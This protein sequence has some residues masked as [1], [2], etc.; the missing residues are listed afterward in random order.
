[1]K[2]KR[3]VSRKEQYEKLSAACE[4][5][6]K[7]KKE[8]IHTLAGIGRKHKLLRYPILV[9]LVVFIFIYNVILYGCIQLK[10]REKFARGV[11]FV[12]TLVLVLTS[13]NAVTFATTKRT[14]GGAQS[15][16]VITAFSGLDESVAKQSL[17][18]GAKE[19]GITFPD[20]LTVTLETES[21]EEQTESTEAKEKTTS[22]EGTEAE[23][24]TTSEESTESEGNT[25]EESTPESEEA[26]PADEKSNSADTPSSGN[27][28]SAIFNFLL[29]EPMIVYAAGLAETK[30]SIDV[31]WTLDT[32]ASTS[33][34]F[35]SSEAGNRYVY[36]PVIPDEYTVAEGVSL[37]QIIVTVID[38]EQTTV[39]QIIGWQFGE[40]NVFPEGALF[41]DAGSYS[42]VLA[43]GDSEVQ[44]PFEEIASC[45]PEN[46]LVKYAEEA[47]DDEVLPI[48]GWSCPEYTTDEEGNLPYSGSFFFTALLAEN[49]EEGEY[50]F[51]EEVEP[52]GVW[53]IFDAPM[54]TSV[55]AAPGTITSDQEWEEQ[56]LAAG[57]YII[58]EGVTVT[59]SG[60][61]TV[62]GTVTIK[63]GG[64]LVRS[65]SYAGTSGSGYNSALLY[66]TGGSLTL[67][68][69][70]IDGNF[71]EAYGPAVYISSGTVTLNSGAVIQNNYNMN[72][73]SGAGTYAA[74]GIY[75]AGTLNINGGTIQNCRTN[76]EIASSAYSYAGGGIYLKGTCNMTSGSITGNSASN[77]G[78]IYLASGATLDLIGGII[79][80]NS[81]TGNGN[82]IYY[83]TV[84]NT[85]GIL[86]IG[87]D[88][89]ISDTIYLD[90]TKGTLYPLITSEL[91]Y[92][93]TLNCNISEEGKVLARGS[94]YTLTDAD[95]SKIT[96]ENSGLYSV[97]DTDNNQII[98]REMEA[99]W[100]ETSGGEW[101]Y[102]EFTTAL[103]NVYSGGTIKLL[104]D[105]V[106]TEKV[107]IAKTVTITSNDTS[108]PCTI[109]RMPT[110]TYG[111]IT[112]T[113]SGNLTLT[114]IIYDGNRDYVSGGGEAQ[115][116]I[117]VGDT[118]NQGTALILGNGCVIRNGYKSGGSGV[119]A[120]YGTMTMES[121]AV[122]ENCQVTGT[123]GAVWVS[124]D[125]TFIMNGGTI[126]NCA[127][128]DGGSAVS[129]DGT[130]LLNGGSITGNTD[131]SDKTCDV[132]L[133]SSGS[134]SL[135]LNGV[136]ISGNTYSVYNEGKN[137]MITGDST[138]LGSIYT[139]NAVTASG[140][141]V[142]GL[143]KTYTITM[144]SVTN[145]TIVVKDSTDS[146]H[147]QLDSSE[148]VLAANGT[149]LWAAKKYTVTYD[150]SM[151]GGICA[152]KTSDMFG[153]GNQ[154]DLTPTAT[155]DGWEFVG[156]NTDKDAKTGLD[157]LTMET[158][159]MTLYAVYKKTLTLTCYSGSAGDKQTETVTIYNNDTKGSL[160]VPV[161]KAW[162]VSDE[163]YRFHHYVLGPD[164]FEGT[165]YGG[166]STI[167]LSEDISLYA[168][169]RKTITIS[170]EANEGSGSVADKEIYRSA[171]VS[172]I[173]TYKEASATLPEGTGFT[174]A[175]YTF[176]GWIEGSSI[177]TVIAAGTLVTP[178]ADTTYYASWTPNTYLVELH[179]NG[180]SG[181]TSLTS[182]TCGTGAVLP[183]DWTKSGYIFAGWYDNADCTG[184]EVAEILATDTGN[185]EYWAKWVDDI[186]PEIGTLSYSYQPKNLWQWLIGKESLIIT[187]PV[188][189]EGSGVDEI[190]YIVTEEG[191]TASTD[192]SEIVDGVAKIT[193]SADFKGTIVLFCTDK[194]GNT[195]SSVAVGSDMNGT[196]IIIEDNAPDIT[197][198][199]DGGDVSP[200]EY[201]LAPEI[202]VTV[203]DD[204]DN[205]ISAGIASVTYQIGNGVETEVQ[206]DF[207]TSMKNQVSFTIA[208]AQIPTGRTEI[209]VKA[210]DNAGNLSEKKFTVTV[211]VHSGNLVDAEAATCTE[212][213]HR[214]YYICSC[215]K[216]FSDSSCTKEVT[217][218]E[219]AILATGH[220]SVTDAA[221]AATCTKT[222]LTKGSHCS[223][224]GT[225]IVEQKTIKALG[226]DYSGNYR[227]DATGHWKVCRRC[228]VKNTKHN[229]I[230]NDDRDTVCNDCGYER[231]VNNPDTEE[232]EP[233]TPKPAETS[234]QN[235]E[236]T[237]GT[238]K[239]QQPEEAGVHTIPAS[240]DKGKMTISGG[241]VATG[242]VKGMTNTST[243][244]K[245]GDGAVIITIAC[246]EKEYT[247][248]VVDTVAV[249]NAVLTP[250]QIQ[251]VAD[252]ETIEIR[253]TV[254]DISDNVPPQDKEIIER[255]IKV[256]QNELPGLT[257]GMYV[258]ISMSIK[259]GAG[260]WNIVTTTK[261]AIEVVIGIPEK[262]QSDGREYYIIRSHEGEYTLLTD[263]DENPDTITIS[264]DMFSAYAIVYEQADGAEVSVKCRLCHIC[265]TFLGICYFIWLVIIIA[266][267]L[268]IWIVIRRNRKKE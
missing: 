180:G 141:G 44:I 151:N 104:K 254:T 183:T 162:S 167:Y 132:Y 62:N 150:Y 181:G 175:G 240:I 145:G 34:T 226:H 158:E 264:T 42:L 176:N 121:G 154:V 251:L 99:I 95:V 231:T 112:L 195:S 27:E 21:E 160:K 196:G 79:S 215:G 169:Y 166:G 47:I 5:F 146:T 198:Q 33:K 245:L 7:A 136:A 244:L 32:A 267:F 63:G 57:T 110:G 217:A 149:N 246:E 177:G 119:I 220:R 123:G 4:P 192:T 16:G 20:A 94:S 40:E 23:E 187:V 194:A 78:G 237:S 128:A 241:A 144:S 120:V 171:N 232:G 46:V 191:S 131:A 185:K 155:K 115:S 253:I 105:I 219:V 189:E 212:D 22:E 81:A 86:K 30:T 227:Y 41:Y 134:G 106:F 102:G 255:G 66:V 122:I 259:I 2:M 37:P 242:N 222:G 213:G 207:V 186:A 230:Y 83:S 163:N 265:P 60:R 168:W 56:T 49:G 204:K 182:Y 26:S 142:S 38:K 235:T 228:G 10:I 68:N 262:L 199:A 179:L 89:N 148:Y 8:T 210:T 152:T 156:W 80:G 216:W 130:C 77:G 19:S 129:V 11:A 236:E 257:L 153:A 15:K 54:K 188:T 108:N 55:T 28:V 202:T 178:T 164:K 96:L 233:E 197:F 258:D 93:I 243:V 137:V 91:H 48:Y 64:K 9:A 6:R 58:N 53:V 1:M 17:P 139:T 98:L 263:I 71:V 200:G 172:D 223:V 25:S 88:A 18:V 51:S 208:A 100:Q 114:G 24:K 193:V 239:E 13:M 87:G 221:K 65:G 238:K 211:H 92:P 117:K 249:A 224:C 209:I 229:H 173:V 67:E 90:I 3:R 261:E 157:S 59:V 118:G 29:P 35:D 174:R 165:I 116:L 85:N 45:L 268:I 206:Q 205:A 161:A 225:S 14:G 39:P 126:Q 256:Y 109:T 97:L 107:E 69:I 252:G 12:M 43:G 143:T 82:G 70:T 218:Q 84:N 266:A 190:V 50:V 61:L 103:E 52:I 73:N 74:G 31:T 111:N 72:P 135:T 203:T 76:G 147:Y 36:V 250:E 124:S 125:S 101:K 247:A 214:A 234:E 138:L 159:D 184:T 170:Y 248:G 127:A 75:C 113:G 140:A 201:A 260:D 133:R